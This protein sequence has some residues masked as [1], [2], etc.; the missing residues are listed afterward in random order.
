MTQTFNYTILS[1]GFDLKYFEIF[2]SH[3]LLPLP[4]TGHKGKKCILM[5]SLDYTELILQVWNS[6]N[7][8]FEKVV[9]CQQAFLFIVHWFYLSFSIGLKEKLFSLKT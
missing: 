1:L 4:N 9:S 5:C 6:C 7:E 3:P 8:V 2:L